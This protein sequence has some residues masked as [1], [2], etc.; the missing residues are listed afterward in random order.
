MISSYPLVH[1]AVQVTQL[2]PTQY[3]QHGTFMLTIT[4][5]WTLVVD[6]YKKLLQ[7]YQKHCKC[8]HPFSSHLITF[9]QCRFCGWKSRWFGAIHFEQRQYSVLHLSDTMYV[10]IR[11]VCINMIVLLLNQKTWT[12]STAS[13]N[14]LEECSRRNHLVCAVSWSQVNYQMF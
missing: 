3:L 11:A 14:M 10:F 2:S 1:T 12:Y 8:K 4:K 7:Q 5:Y 13:N 9:I 6:E